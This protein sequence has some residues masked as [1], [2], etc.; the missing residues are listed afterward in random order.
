MAS[1]AQRR[2]AAKGRAQAASAPASTRIRSSVDRAKGGTRATVPMPRSGDGV[3]REEAIL[4]AAEYQYGKGSSQVKAARGAVDKARMVPGEIGGVQVLT[5]AHV[6]DTTRQATEYPHGIPLTTAQIHKRERLFGG[7]T[8]ETLPEALK[9]KTGEI[10]KYV[11]EPLQKETSRAFLT[12]QSEASK[13][14]TREAQLFLAEQRLQKYD[15]YIKDGVFT[16][17]K[18]QYA[19]YAA[20]FKKYEA[21]GGRYTESYDKYSEAFTQAEGSQAQL[22]EA[23]AQL[24]EAERAKYGGLV[25]KYEDIETKIKDSPYAP[26]SEQEVRGYLKEQEHE[27]TF[28]GSMVS[29][30]K[31]VRDQPDIFTPYPSR[32]TPMQ[33]FTSLTGEI[34][35]SVVEGQITKQPFA[36]TAQRVEWMGAGAIQEIHEKP[37]KAPVTLAAMAAISIVAPEIAALGKAGRAVYGVGR[38]AAYGLGAA[39]GV[40]V[41]GRTFVDIPETIKRGEYVPLGLSEEAKFRTYGAIGVTEILPMMAGVGIG[42]VYK[43][44]QFKSAVGKAYQPIGKIGEHIRPSK[45]KEFVLAEPVTYGGIRTGVKA[46][47]K[48]YLYSDYVKHMLKLTVDTTGSLKFKVKPKS[49]GV[50]VVKSVKKG[51]IDRQIASHI[52]K[53][54]AELGRSLFESEVKEIT[55]FYKIGMPKTQ[56][57]VMAEMKHESVIKHITELTQF[58]NQKLRIYETGRTDISIKELLRSV[59]TGT[60][61]EL[62]QPVFKG[63]LKTLADIKFAKQELK[64]LLKNK[65]ITK[66]EYTS[67][68]KVITKQEHLIKGDSKTRTIVFSTVGTVV[69]QDTKQ[70]QLDVSKQKA[71]LLT[72]AMLKTPQIQRPYSETIIKAMSATEAKAKS[73]T[74]RD[75]L[76]KSVVGEAMF[77]PIAFI[78]PPLLK[79]E[80]KKRSKKQINGLRQREWFITNP[81][82]SVFNTGK[83]TTSKKNNLL[84][85]I[86]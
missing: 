60:K 5:P 84:G 15:K 53:R 51:A 37:L 32:S 14:Q 74:V 41:A 13:V 66:T 85:R 6:P 17:S 86:K 52:K 58:K 4:K 34:M 69:R 82:A 49:E 71:R 45:I 26:P 59:S 81:I 79:K 9:G 31:T 39:Y 8:V 28:V 73:K 33:P 70:P 68:L 18:G 44:P 40:S 25:G 48:R 65:T 56:S 76:Y 50:L 22:K 27:G 23:E 29:G 11:V 42:E 57:E 10:E 2:W 16:G 21:A 43:T 55:D 38:G 35:P 78:P 64:V 30:F 1:A 77:K 63:G 3:T 67:L 19:F 20:D 83:K 7:A 62:F 47:P 72:I 12:T 36:Q 46:L 80:D 24:K 75:P 54:E 61:P